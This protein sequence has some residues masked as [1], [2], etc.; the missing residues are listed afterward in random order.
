MG[1]R[2]ETT[3]YT[4][5]G[6]PLLVRLWD[7]SFSGSTLPFSCERIEVQWRGDEARERFSP[8]IGSECSLSLIVS[9]SDLETFVTDLV[10]AEEGRFTVTVAMFA[11]LSAPFTWSGYI[12]TDNVRIED[13]TLEVGYRVEIRAVDGLGRLKS[14][15]YNNDGTQYA[16]KETFVQHVLKALNKLPFIT[17]LF[18]PSD[19]LLNV[20]ANWHE[21]SYTYA[22]TIN[23]MNRAR[24]SHGA[25]YYRDTKGNNVYSSAYEVLEEICT[26]WGAR[27][28]FSGN[29]FWLMQVGEGD[30]LASVNVFRYT[31]GGTESV[32]TAQDLT[33]FHFPN[34]AGNKLLRFSGGAFE[35]FVPL[36]S[37]QVDYRH[38]QSRNLLAGY[39]WSDINNTEVTVEDI[40][41]SDGEGRLSY[42]GTLTINTSWIN[43]TGPAFQPHYVVLAFKVQVG[44]FFLNGDVI[45]TPTG[46]VADNMEWNNDSASRMYV[47]TP[48]FQFDGQTI[49][50][51]INFITPPLEQSGDLTFSFDKYKAYYGA[52]EIGFV[53]GDP[54]LILGYQLTNNYLELL[55]DGTFENQADIYR[56]KST[57]DATA[58]KR[59]ELVTSIGDGPNL[60][61]PGHIEVKDDTDEWVI[62]DAWRVG[63]L[64][65][66][67]AFS[68]LLA[69]ET[70]RGQLLPVKKLS[71]MPFQNLDS[72]SNP[73][74]PHLAIDY[75]SAKWLFLAGRYNVQTEIWQ[76]DWFKVQSGTG[77]TEETMQLIP[78]DAKDG[79]PTSGGTGGTAPTGGT[80][81]TG[82]STGSAGNTVRVFRQEFLNNSDGELLITENG[83]ALPFVE[84]Q[85]QVFQNGQKLLPVQYDIVS[86]TITIDADT[87]F[88]GANYEVYFTIIQ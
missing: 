34:A 28:V 11:G 72:P 44:S 58:S 86:S 74:R 76:G 42:T 40:D 43:V 46:P 61:S 47:V 48:V 54:Y 79:A 66:Y 71:G 50:F 75:D 59:V 63:N 3:Y 80:S 73:L 12:T 19:T 82:G 6:N 20:V 39:T 33:M 37:V 35:F 27:L 56:Y 53:V 84:I 23:P 5:K 2:L 10:G 4:E 18:G 78:K 45:A 36:K 67:K 31:K 68:Q 30:N 21:N 8:I 16:G 49:A 22:A 26:A 24:V 64:G 13:T 62:S 69:N 60:A 51:P 1:V 70:I 9:N 17:S 81:T 25:F 55:G 7:S 38:I 88:V 85:I 57:N 52:D 87:H 77:Y 14:V 83:G 41:D 29:A 15:D 65:D 32:A